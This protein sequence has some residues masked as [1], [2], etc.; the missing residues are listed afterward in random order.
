VQALADVEDALS[1]LWQVFRTFMAGIAASFAPAIQ[2]ITH[3]FLALYK[4]NREFLQ[5]NMNR[6]FADIT[7]AMGFVYGILEALVIKF[8]RFVK[9]H[10]EL[11]KWVGYLV[12]GLGALAIV[13]AA[14]SA[15]F[16]AIGAVF[17][18]ISV[19]FSPL[20]LGVGA[21][22]LAI[23]DLWTLL[24]GGSWEDTWLSKMLTAGGKGIAWLMEKMGLVDPNAKPGINGEGVPTSIA[25]AS[26]NMDVLSDM[27]YSGVSASMPQGGAGAP[28]SVD[29]SAPITINVPPGTDPR[30]VGEAARQ[31]VKDHLDQLSREMRRSLKPAQAY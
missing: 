29:M 28:V 14:V 18:A 11:V 21:V 26:Q 9:E 15:I 31:G 4:A 3:W 5:L 23:H 22:T 8:M 17:G 19:L 30:Q 24:S 10:G 16:G 2:N 25:R 27:S 1:Q 20:V 7:Y 13:G 12:L 6:W